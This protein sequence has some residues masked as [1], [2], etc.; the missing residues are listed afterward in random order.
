MKQK[1]NDVVVKCTH[2]K[3]GLG[4]EQKMVKSLNIDELEDSHSISLM[5]LEGNIGSTQQQIIDFLYGSLQFNGKGVVT[6]DDGQEVKYIVFDFLMFDRV[7]LKDYKN[8]QNPYDTHSSKKPYPFIY[9]GKY[10]E[11]GV[12]YDRNELE[13]YDGDN[14]LY[15]SRILDLFQYADL[16][17]FG[18]APASPDKYYCPECEHY[19]YVD[20]DIGKEHQMATVNR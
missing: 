17:E 18:E 2:L 4:G 6:I 8:T 3:V 12:T 13:Q 5:E 7:M 19:H 10:G 14:R 1:K 11:Y 15:Q 20:S 9:K 16:V